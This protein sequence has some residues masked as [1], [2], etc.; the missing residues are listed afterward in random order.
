VYIYS[1]DQSVGVPPPPTDHTTDDSVWTSHRDVPHA[2]NTL[3][4]R[5][6]VRLVP[7]GTVPN[8]VVRSPKRWMTT[9][10]SEVVE[11]V[12]GLSF[13]SQYKFSFVDEKAMWC[14]KLRSLV[15]LFRHRRAPLVAI[16]NFV[17]HNQAESGYQISGPTGFLSHL[18]LSKPLPASPCKNRLNTHVGMC[19]SWHC[20]DMTIHTYAYVASHIVE[21]WYRTK[22]RSNPLY[23]NT[24]QRTLEVLRIQPPQK[25]RRTTRC[26]SVS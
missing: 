24:V 22:V 17:A 4:S 6:E 9:S 23:Y 25:I 10:S 3:Q 18:E 2:A 16:R 8:T 5:K 19:H 13:G 7:T 1:H 14:V 11:Q 26:A 12:N 20:D 15:P 21:K